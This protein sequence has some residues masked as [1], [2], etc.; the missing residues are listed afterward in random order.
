ME[1]TMGLLFSEPRILSAVSAAMNWLRIIVLERRIEEEGER[2]HKEG[3]TKS[4]T[5]S[6]P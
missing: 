6:K 3:G 1:Y 5:I 4:S 2:K